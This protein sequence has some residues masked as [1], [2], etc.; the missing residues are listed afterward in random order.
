MKPCLC[1]IHS[2][3]SVN[4]FDIDTLFGSTYGLNYFCDTYSP[5]TVVI[6]MPFFIH[7]HCRRVDWYSFSIYFY[8][9]WWPFI[10][11]YSF[12]LL[13][14]FYYWFILFISH[15][16]GDGSDVFVSRCIVGTYDVTGILSVIR[17]IHLILHW[18]MMYW[19]YI[20]LFTLCWPYLMIFIPD[21][22]LWYSIHCGIVTLHS[23][24]IFSCCL[25]P[26]TLM[27][28]FHSTM[29]FWFI[30]RHFDDISLFSAHCYIFLSLCFCW[31]MIC[32][33]V[34]MLI[35]F[36]SMH[37]CCCIHCHLHSL[38][39]VV[40]FCLMDATGDVVLQSVS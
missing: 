6:P 19:W 28:T 4:T 15:C 30:L 5:F 8:S 36:I 38:H 34:T 13:L 17:C 25:L 10:I 32:S 27:L 39:S 37:C 14:I 7:V 35:P 3:P 21:D 29:L 9:W 18:Y 40:T 33:F 23:F 12:D 2:W 1:Y 20:V 26:T 22:V 11:L 31:L 16:L 24:G